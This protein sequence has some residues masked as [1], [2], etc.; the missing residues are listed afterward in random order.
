MLQDAGFHFHVAR[1]ADKNLLKIR[2][3]PT[4][5]PLSHKSG[6][7]PEYSLRLF[8]DSWKVKRGVKCVSKKEIFYRDGISHDHIVAIDPR[9]HKNVPK[10]HFTIKVRTK[11]D[12]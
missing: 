8:H 5:R 1:D 10:L 11:E 7:R 6:D 3:T 4:G 12:S 2:S 9:T